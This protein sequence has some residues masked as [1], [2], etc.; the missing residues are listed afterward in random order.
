MLGLSPSPV[1]YEGFTKF[2]P[3]DA[4]EIQEERN[5]S[6]KDRAPPIDICTNMTPVANMEHR[7]SDQWQQFRY[8]DGDQQRSV[9]E[10]THTAGNSIY[11][12]SVDNMTLPARQN[13]YAF[14]PGVEL[15]TMVNGNALAA[16]YGSGPAGLTSNLHTSNAGKAPENPH[17][18]RELSMPHYMARERPIVKIAKPLS[19]GTVAVGSLRQNG[20]RDEPQLGQAAMGGSV[21]D[22]ARHISSLASFVTGIPPRAAPL[23]NH[24]DSSSIK[25][26]QLRLAVLQ[27]LGRQQ[28]DIPGQDLSDV[29]QEPGEVSKRRKITHCG[30]IGA[31]RNGKSAQSGA[32]EPQLNPKELPV[33]VPTCADKVSS[34]LASH[35]Q[36]WRVAE[37]HTW[38]LDSNEESCE[39][40]GKHASNV[41][42]TMNVRSPSSKPPPSEGNAD[43]FDVTLFLDKHSHKRRVELA[44]AT[45]KDAEKALQV[46]DDDPDQRKVCAP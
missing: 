39:S 21:N 13:T 9:T 17:E 3:V 33:A 22:C 41:K 23:E 10:S 12:M 15:A 40:L 44:D 8:Q 43:G 16:Y 4:R 37:H 1:R 42:S 29:R 32:G 30:I 25:E 34:F 20:N 14:R 7:I 5:L 2:K 35:A 11:Q 26:K 31:S 6:T 36:I 38:N 46:P 24:V 27:S 45:R 19:S 28:R 18:G